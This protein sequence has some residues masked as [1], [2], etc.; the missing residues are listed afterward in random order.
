[1]EIRY[2]T[3]QK[4]L[5][6]NFTICQSIIKDE[7]ISGNLSAKPPHELQHIRVQLN[8]NLTKRNLYFALKTTDYDGNWAKVSNRATAS[9]IHPSEIPL[10][11]TASEITTENVTVQSAPEKKVD[12]YIWVIVGVLIGVCVFLTVIIIILKKQIFNAR[13]NKNKMVV[14]EKELNPLDNPAHETSLN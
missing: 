4:K 14:S 10:E 8:L 1:M 7:V 2:D 12:N 6:S 9:F 11:E 3:D 5:I 13:S